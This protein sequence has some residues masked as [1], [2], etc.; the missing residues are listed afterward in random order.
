M[1][2]S[3]LEI[4]SLVS[5]W[6]WPFLR[7][8]AFITTVP[9][10]GNRLVPSRVKI[11]IALALTLV[12]APLLTD[13]PPLVPFK[14]EM[15]IVIAQQVLIGLTIGFAVRLALI[16]LEL[17]GQLI[18][19]LMG[20]GFAELVDPQNGVSVPGFSQFYVIAA[21]LVFLAL[22]GHLL[23]VSLLV[24]SFEVLPV[25]GRALE[26]DAL[27]L[28]TGQIGWVFAAAMQLAL[29]AVVTLLI[30]N[31]A[32]GI[33]SRAA[34]QLNIISIGFPMTLALGFVVVWL[35]WRG[36]VD[37]AGA[38]FGQSLSVGD[39]LIRAF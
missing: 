19:H 13:L 20:L 6:V 37:S 25:G 15:V 30:V 4:S 12:I 38:V 35:T 26:V 16:V 10:F 29:P 23:T 2:I 1:T 34:P 22:D 8:A 17:L 39:A 32:F 18:A 24:D 36:F 31:I 14:G 21:T 9:V 5:A 27:W 7:V 11:A 33:V 28:I 3:A